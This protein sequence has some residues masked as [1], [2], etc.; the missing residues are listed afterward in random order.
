MANKDYTV[1]Q[2][3]EMEACTYCKVCADVCPAVAASRDGELSGVYRIKGLKQILK[4]RTGLYRKLFRKKVPSEEQWKQFS[5]TV[6]R[7]TLCG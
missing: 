5:D 1:K 7:C 3:I 4:A 6:F 2:L